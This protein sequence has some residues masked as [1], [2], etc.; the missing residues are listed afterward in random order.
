MVQYHEKP[1]LNYSVT[2]RGADLLTEVSD[3]SL[4]QRSQ[5]HWLQWVANI[6]V[7]GLQRDED[8]RHCI[9]RPSEMHT[10]DSCL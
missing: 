10:T 1:H 3:I 8:V 6:L 2:I 5:S 4:L 9:I 7:Q